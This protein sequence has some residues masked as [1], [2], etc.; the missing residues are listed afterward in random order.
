MQL[1]VQ[2]VQ[3]HTGAALHQLEADAAASLQLQGVSMDSR[4]VQPG[5]LFVA[6]PGARAHGHDY[7]AAA[8]HAGATAALVS[9]AQAVPIPQLVVADVA[10]ALAT[11]ARCWRETLSVTVIGITGSNG[12]TTV[13]EM[14]AAILRRALPDDTWLA[15]AGNYNNELGV[16]LTL[17]RLH[18]QHQFAVIEMGCGQPGDIEF[19]A[20]LALPQIGIVTSVGPAHLQRLGDLTGVATTKSELFTSLPS[21][22]LALFPAATEGAEILRAAAACTV[23]TV[24]EQDAVIAADVRWQRCGDELAVR[25]ATTTVHTILA[26]PGPHHASN[27]ALAVAAALALDI[28]PAHIAAGL[29]DMQAMP[30]RGEVLPGVAGSVIINDSYNANPASLAAAI[31]SL[32]SGFPAHEGWLVL[33]DMGELGDHAE[34]LHARSGQAARDAGLS[35]LFACGPLAAH[36]ATAFGEGACAFAEQAALLAALK[37]QLHANV[38]L[39]VKGSRSAGMEQVV[40]KLAAPGDGQQAASG[41][42]KQEAC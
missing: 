32:R 31:S 38:A 33:G 30:G 5:N 23:Q 14:L 2:D 34:A 25:T 12:K 27:A 13:K 40:T 41:A 24:A 29:A 21:D 28:S 7:L 39:L 22:G 35:R 16:P 42:Q 36:A 9:A 37:P 19:L 6:L 3:R 20:R 11:L 15:T 8:R 10:Q 26:L 17:L 18:Q 4:S 1:S